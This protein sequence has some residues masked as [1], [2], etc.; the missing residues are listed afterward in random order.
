M[1]SSIREVIFLGLFYTRMN[2]CFIAGK[3]SGH[4]IIATQLA[5]TRNDDRSISSHR[6][7]MLLRIKSW[8]YDFSEE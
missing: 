6:I 8:K 2:F 7:N 5:R 1:S 4:G 3:G